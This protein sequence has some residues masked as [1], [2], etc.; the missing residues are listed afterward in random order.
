[1]THPLSVSEFLL[2]YPQ[3]RRT[4]RPEPMYPG[5]PSTDPEMH[6]ATGGVI[7]A[8]SEM[9]EYLTDD[10][11]ETVVWWILQAFEEAKATITK[12]REYGSDELIYAGRITGQIHS[13]HTEGALTD[14]QAAELMIYFYVL[15]KMGRWTAAMRRGDFVSDDTLLD[16]GIYTRMVQR[17]RTT[18]QWP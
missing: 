6:T 5:F 10:P 12:A 11:D 4:E 7:D 1:M 16:I 18:G 13:R 17:L 3:Y 9:V 14:A 2:K 8:V 15:G